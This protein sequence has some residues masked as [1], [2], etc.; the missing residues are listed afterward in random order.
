LSFLFFCR[1]LGAGSAIE[2]LRHAQC[3]FWQTF[4]GL[5]QHNVVSVAQTTDGYIWAGTIGTSNSLVRFN[6]KE[7]VAAMKLGGGLGDGGAC[8]AP[9]KNGRLWVS[10]AL[11]KGGLLLW[12]H[13]KATAVNLELPAAA[14]WVIPLFEDPQ[15]NLW[16]GG[17]GLLVRTPA[18]RIK[19]FCSLTNQYGLI[20]RIAA[21]RQGT[22][23][24]ATDHGLVRCRNEVFDQPYYALTNAL[25]T[26]CPASDGS[27]WLGGESEPVLVQVTP[28]REIVRYAHAPGFAAGG[29]AAICED[30]KSNLWLGTYSGLCCVKGRWVYPAPAQ[31]LKTV[32][33][34][35]LICDREGSLWAGT[36]DGL[37]RV[38]DSP[39]EY[40]GPADVLGPVDTLCAG[41]S[42]LWASVYVG[43][44]FLYREHA[45]KQRGPSETMSADD[46]V[47]FPPGELWMAVGHKC[48]RF[49]EG[50]SQMLEAITGPMRLCTDGQGV[51]I[52]TAT[53]LFYAGKGQDAKRVDHWP[54]M[55]V[56]AVT[57]NAGGGLLI[58]TTQGVSRWAGQL[59]P[60]LRFD[61]DFPGSRAN[62]L[63][64][65]GQSLWVA[66]D[67]AI[68]RCQ[69]GQ[70][71]VI[72][73]E[74]GLAET[75][76]INNL[77]VDRENLWLGCCKGLF[78][79]SRAQVEACLRGARRQAALVQY[80][81]S[82]GVHP[83]F[84][85]PGAWGQGAARD[86]EGKLWFASKNGLVAI[87]PAIPL[88]PIAPPV[89][90]ESLRLDQAPAVS[91]PEP[92]GPPL[93]LPAGTRSVEL[94]YA[95]LT[96]IAP[97]KARFKCRLLGLDSDWV[98]AGQNTVAHYAKLAPGNYEFQVTACNSD[99]VWNEQGASVK[100][101]QAPFFYQTPL[102]LVWCQVAAVAAGLGLATAAAAVAHRIS[103]RKMRQRLARI[104][105]QQRLDRERARIARDIHDDLG[106]TLTRIVMLTELGRREPERTHTPDG[107][108]TAIQT[109]ARE[110]TRRLDE[111][112]WAVSPRHD[113]LEALVAY[114]GKMATDQARAAGLRCR[115]D[116]PPNLP[117]WPLTGHARHS[118]YLACKEAVHNAVKHAHPTELRLRLVI[119]AD[120]LALDICD[121][122]AGLPA[123]LDE[124]AGDGFPNLRQR[125]AALG[126]TCQI[127]S[128]P[129][130]GT[131]VTLGLPRQVS[132]EPVS[133][134]QGTCS[135]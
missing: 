85:G 27:L 72:R 100:L 1:A 89:V 113:T 31:D 82:Q 106:S 97:E 37:Y 8:V 103:T 98:A 16:I 112:V 69:A 40:Y 45:W 83:A 10:Q 78:R 80:D 127:R 94:S 30:L 22:I 14:Q 114:I 88:N 57:T 51:W 75:G 46:L 2:P 39:F 29:V 12:E 65:E 43:G 68:G 70:W 79:L 19:D 102:F 11:E 108:L 90:I 24:L 5:P 49:R 93:R 81:R 18:G 76:G 34:F 77:L 52:I 128:A 48:Y 21:D 71:R 135:P 126:G 118:L 86:A 13:G 58:G 41:P 131:T 105:A 6:G 60:W 87:N 132:S 104:E 101:V 44:L 130:E 133:T 66:S 121:N 67:V 3:D 129:G 55:E 47:E 92:A 125:L 95:A 84:F 134:K 26:V 33:I 63:E 62:S 17:Q 7:F 73:P 50:R 61:A 124:Q 38:R 123:D 115:L 99:G 54:P 28:A 23:W 59:V 56:T 110:I 25:L 9:G 36:A 20:R 32:Y 117:A 15:E 119:Q 64:W 109:A 4:D 91:L 116:F 122:G 107:H 53:E 96:F 74:A 35:C 111:I 120:G 42:G